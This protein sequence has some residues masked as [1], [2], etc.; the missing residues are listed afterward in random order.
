MSPQKHFLTLI[1]VK[2]LR[3]ES[4]QLKT[5]QNENKFHIKKKYSFYFKIT[6]KRRSKYDCVTSYQNVVQVLL[7]NAVVTHYINNHIN[8]IYNYIYSY[9]YNYITSCK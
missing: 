4:L 9:L 7:G 2:T 8:Y 6:I 3:K 5:L 1:S